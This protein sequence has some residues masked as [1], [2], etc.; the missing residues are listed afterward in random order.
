MS[1]FIL[2]IQASQIGFCFQLFDRLK[3]DTNDKYCDQSTIL[4]RCIS[5]MI[6]IGY[7][8]SGIHNTK[9]N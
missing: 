5:K 6:E 3:E 7:E 9:T 1:P 8:Y 4:F 2:R